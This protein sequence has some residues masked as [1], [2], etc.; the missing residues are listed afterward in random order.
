MAQESLAIQPKNEKVSVQEMLYYD[1]IVGLVQKQQ[2]IFDAHDQ[3]QR[4]HYPYICEKSRQIAGERTLQDLI[5]ESTKVKKTTEP[6][7]EADV[8]ASQASKEILEGF[9]KRNYDLENER[10]AA[11]KRKN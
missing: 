3:E 6:K 4:S 5:L 10:R 11:T 8:H 2:K 9:L 1:A 7:V